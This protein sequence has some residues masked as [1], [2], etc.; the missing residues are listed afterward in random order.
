MT[1]LL[2][3]YRKDPLAFRESVERQARRVR[4]EYVKGVLETLRLAIRDAVSG[5]FRD[6]PFGNHHRTA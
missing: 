2:E 5:S 4:R 1:D 3:T 6:K